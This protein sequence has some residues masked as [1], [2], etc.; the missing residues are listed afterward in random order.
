MD[1]QENQEKQE[2]K[3]QKTFKQYYSDPTFKEKHLT[4]IKQ[5]ITC[6]VCGKEYAR[7]NMSKHKQSNKHKRNE[8]K[9]TNNMTYLQDQNLIDAFKVIQEHFKNKIT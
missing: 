7:S 2:L 3:S 8:K 9:E 6:G 4:Y 5:K 1:N